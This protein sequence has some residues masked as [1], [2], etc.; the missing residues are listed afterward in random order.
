MPPT[1]LSLDYRCVECG[2]PV[3]ALLR[4]TNGMDVLV[5]CD[6]CGGAADPFIEHDDVHLCIS[7]ILLRAAAWRHL[8]FNSKTAYNVVVLAAAAAVVV[9]VATTVLLGPLAD[10]RFPFTTVHSVAP[11]AADPS[12]WE[13]VL[14]MVQPLPGLRIIN[15]VNNTMLHGGWEAAEPLPHALVGATIE[16]ALSLIA[17][18]WLVS[19]LAPKQR[20]PS[21]RSTTIAFALTMLVR[22]GGGVYFVWEAPL[23]F[24]LLMDLTGIMWTFKAFGTLTGAHVVARAFATLFAYSFTRVVARTLTGWCPILPYLSVIFE[25]HAFAGG[26]GHG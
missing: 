14:A 22:L 24:L 3:D 10:A 18:L 15:L 20:V 4:K 5:K 8:V 19:A 17:M 11:P 25:G 16:S 2:A 6:R 23:Y 9:D 1:P 26:T 13:A 7:V 12:S 21:R